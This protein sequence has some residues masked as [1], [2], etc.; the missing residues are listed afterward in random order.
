MLF[1]P[2]DPRAI[3][4][5]RFAAAFNAGDAAPAA[6]LFAEDAELQVTK[7]VTWKGRRRR[8]RRG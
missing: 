6:L 2:A 8:S 7:A 5:W 3:T 1:F 4:L